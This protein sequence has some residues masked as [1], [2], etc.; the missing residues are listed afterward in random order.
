MLYI[1]SLAWLAEGDRHAWIALRMQHP[2]V[3]GQLHGIEAGAQAGL[4]LG[5][6]RLV[7]N[8]AMVE[9]QA[10]Q[11]EAHQFQ[12]GTHHGA[13]LI[14]VAHP[15]ERASG[16]DRRHAQAEGQVAGVAPQVQQH[17]SGQHLSDGGQPH[18]AD[19]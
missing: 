13:D 5:H 11:G 16:A 4:R 8:D 17:R 2:R 3:H 19:Q 15:A 14:E 12:V 1:G 9:L 18:P 10:L 6:Q 7:V